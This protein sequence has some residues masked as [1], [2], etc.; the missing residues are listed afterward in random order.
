[1]D[2]AV[3]IAGLP[4]PSRLVELVRAGKWVAPDDEILFEI[5][6]QRPVQPCFYGEE[7]LIRENHAWQADPGNAWPGDLTKEGNLGILAE[8]SM[9]IADL[10][11]EMPIVLDYRES[12]TSPR[13]IYMRSS[14]WRQ[15]AADFGE[16]V[17]RLYPG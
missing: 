14:A 8:R 7:M 2:D 11:P 16:L 9:V 1:M 17:R 12:L 13:V 15:I 3:V 5:F 6:E 10:G 4:V